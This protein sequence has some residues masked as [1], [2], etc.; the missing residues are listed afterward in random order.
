KIEPRMSITFTCT[1][2][3]CGTRST[4]EF[5]KRS[6]ERGIVIVECPGC[7]NRHLIADHLGWFNTE[8]S[9]T[10]TVED[11]LQA[12]GEKVRRGHRDETGGVVEY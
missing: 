6:Y 11:I 12:R 8:E 4:H 9:K 2:P 5:A 7:H 1:V 10:R 3:D